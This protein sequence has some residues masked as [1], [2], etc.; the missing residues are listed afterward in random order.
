ME[1]Y[2][3]SDDLWLVENAVFLPKSKTLV[4]SDLQLGYEQ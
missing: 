1:P 2:V 3:V 4:I